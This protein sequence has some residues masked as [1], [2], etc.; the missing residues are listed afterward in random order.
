MRRLPQIGW[1]GLA[2]ALVFSAFSVTPAP[3]A[4]V[5]RDVLR[6]SVRTTVVG[7]D[8]KLEASSTVGAINANVLENLVTTD[9]DGATIRPQLATEWKAESPTNWVFKLRPNVKFHDGTPFNAEAVKF[10][11]ERMTEQDSAQRGD[12][13]WLQEVQVVDAL[14]VRIRSKF[15]YA[16]MLSAL[17]HQQQY[18]LSPTAVRQMGN[19]FG[20]K[21][22]GTG[23]FK[24]DSHIPRQRTIMVRNDE[25]WGPKP[26]VS[27]VEWIFV[28]E[29]N[30]RLAALLGGELDILT[31]IEPSIMLALAGNPKFAVIRGPDD[32][33]DRVGFNAKKRPFDDPRVRK[34]VIH[35]VNR[36]QMLATIFG[37]VGVAFDPPYAPGIWGYDPPTMA[38][39]SYP[40]DPQK[41]RALL[42]EAGFPNGFRTT[43]TIINRPDHRQIGEVIQS[44]LKQVGIDLQLRAFDFATVSQST[45][46]G[47]HDMYI[48][49][50]YGVGDPDRV[51]P[52]FE[53]ANMNIRNRNF[54]SDPE[55]DRLILEQRKEIDPLKRIV[56]V[57]QIGAKIRDAAP[58]FAL[59]WRRSVQA[60]N[61]NV[62]GYRIHPQ[63]W[64]VR[65]VSVEP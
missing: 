11:L 14:T 48:I 29:E 33:V 51:L 60:V 35:A 23:P 9:F 38:R 36:N 10:G 18:V 3:A 62:K 21:P 39:L 37:G 44:D 24:Y 8:P 59:R 46:Q 40:Y 65:D 49:G 30:A 54:W 28:P 12:F 19:Q 50:T 22:V 27:R 31:I 17:A 64:Y 41:S 42:A 45:R 15:A 63:K 6:M 7:L 61:K 56:L 47:D 25:Y 20:Q 5:S 13:S 16:P 32:L 34:A 52:E 58:E 26:K 2:L 53:S 55:V 1:I 4:P 57:R 43:F